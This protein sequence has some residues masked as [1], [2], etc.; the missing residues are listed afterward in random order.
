MGKWNKFPLLL[1]TISNP[2]SR[3]AHI[4]LNGRYRPFLR[5]STCSSW[6]PVCTGHWEK[7]LLLSMM[8]TDQPSRGVCAPHDDPSIPAIK[9]SVYFPWWQ[10]CPGCRTGFTPGGTCH[11]YLGTHC[12]DRCGKPKLPQVAR[13]GVENGDMCKRNHRKEGTITGESLDM[14]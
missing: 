2:P 3:G 1:M 12:F 11:K 14:L 6:W 9:G 8:G 4:S 10:F 7:G 13:G 5:E